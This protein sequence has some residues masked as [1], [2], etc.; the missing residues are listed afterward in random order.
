MAEVEPTRVRRTVADDKTFSSAAF[1][2]WED[3]LEKLKV[4]DYEVNFCRTNGLQPFSRMYFSIPGPNASLQWRSFQEISSWLINLA[5]GNGKNDFFKVDKYDDPNTAVNK[6]M[7]ALD[8]MGFEL[9]FSANRLKQAYGD[10]VCSVLTFLADK[11]LEA[12]GHVWRRAM[13][14]EEEDKEEAEPEDDCDIGDIADEAELEVEE[15]A[16]ERIFIDINKARKGLILS[17]DISF[18]D[19]QAAMLE[20][21]VD[22]VE[23]KRELERVGPRLKMASVAAGKEWRGHVEQTKKLEE[24]IQAA[25]PV[26]NMQLALVR[27]EMTESVEKVRAKERFLNNQHDSL[28]EDYRELDDEVKALETKHQTTGASVTELTDTLA[29]LSEELQ[30]LKEKMDTRGDVMNEASPL[31][32]IKQAIQEIKAEIKT[33]D[34]RIG[35]VSHTLLS[36]RIRRGKANT[37]AGGAGFGEIGGGRK[38][39]PSSIQVGDEDFD[40]SDSG[41]QD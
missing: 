19:S 26:T 15:D 11:A 21:K 33:F 24:A 10:A 41:D 31:V 16:E 35:V 23:W 20:T 13:H 29:A 34:L 8:G 22:P 39:D 28:R 40:M 27:N 9:N 25:L 17:E 7:L 38:G 14:A 6:I 32:T 18:N 1:M 30:E 36:T 3:A 12:S 2:A 5:A 4:L 37:K